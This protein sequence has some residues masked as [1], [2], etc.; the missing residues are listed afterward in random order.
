M[1]KISRKY[2]VSYEELLHRVKEESSILHTMNRRKA[3]WTG[4]TLRRNCTMTL[5]KQEDTGN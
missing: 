3:N 5:R 2:R 1:E 4:H